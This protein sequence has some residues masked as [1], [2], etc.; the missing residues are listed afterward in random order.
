MT[1][2]LLSACSIEQWG[3]INLTDAQIVTAVDEK[4]M[5]VQIRDIFPR[6]TSKVSCWMQWRNAKI[7]TQLV[8]KWH[9]VTDDI[10]ILDYNFTIPKKDGTGSVNLSMPSDKPLPS[11]QYRL[12]I[13]LGRRVLKSLTF[14]IE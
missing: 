14:R 12:D 3:K 10:R 4:L 2:C 5:P 6:G 11:G 13:V 1:A 8:A 7:N 9:Y